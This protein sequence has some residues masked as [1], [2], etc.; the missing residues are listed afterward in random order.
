MEYKYNM[1]YFR[2]ELVIRDIGVDDF[3]KIS[4]S[5]WSDKIVK[6]QLM[7]TDDNVKTVASLSLFENN[8]TTLGT[9]YFYSTHR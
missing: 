2:P 8:G 3:P 5:S 4:Q 7:W 1:E 9:N 6:G